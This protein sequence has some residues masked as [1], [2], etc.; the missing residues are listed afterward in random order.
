MECFDWRVGR[1][2]IED[3]LRVFLPEIETAERERGKT[4][5]QVCPR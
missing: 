5:K 4:S 1:G 2:K 3:N